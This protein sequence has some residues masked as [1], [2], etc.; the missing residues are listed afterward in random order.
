MERRSDG[1]MSGG[2][3][4][5]IKGKSDGWMDGEQEDQMLRREW[6]GVMDGEQED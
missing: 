6:G 3:G 5:W 4:K 2:R 1:W